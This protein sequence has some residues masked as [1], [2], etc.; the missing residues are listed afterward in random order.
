MGEREFLTAAIERLIEDAMG[1]TVFPCRLK[2]KRRPIPKLRHVVEARR[3]ICSREFDSICEALDIGHAARR[4]IFATVKAAVL[5]EPALFKKR[6][7][8]P[9]LWYWFNTHS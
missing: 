4:D 1:F 9:P 8:R 2:N 7:Y 3:W 5:D 6:N